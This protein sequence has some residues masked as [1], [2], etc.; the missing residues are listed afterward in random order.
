MKKETHC[1][2]FYQFGNRYE[3]QVKWNE[4]VEQWSWWLWFNSD[5]IGQEYSDLEPNYQNAKAELNNLPF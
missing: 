4:I 1:F 2:I 3:Y 5:P